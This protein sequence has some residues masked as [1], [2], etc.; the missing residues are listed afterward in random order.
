MRPVPRSLH[1]CTNKSTNPIARLK[2]H[3]AIDIAHKTRIISTFNDAKHELFGKRFLL[4]HMKNKF[5]YFRRFCWR[6]A[7]NLFGYSIILFSGEEDDG[8]THGNS[9][10][11]EY[12]LGKTVMCDTFARTPQQPNQQRTKEKRRKIPIELS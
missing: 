8:Q 7:H 4:F 11:L 2:T 3:F 1:R 10:E 12:S 5:I 9:Q 6:L